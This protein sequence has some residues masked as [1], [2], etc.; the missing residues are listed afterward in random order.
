MGT[1]I[2]LFGSDGHALQYQN[3]VKK[4]GKKFIFEGPGKDP[5]VVLPGLKAQLIE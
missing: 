1:L 4:F 5:F 3:S 2:C